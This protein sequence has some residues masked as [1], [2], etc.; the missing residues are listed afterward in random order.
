MCKKKSLCSA[1]IFQLEADFKERRRK[2]G[3]RILALSIDVQG[4]KAVNDNIERSAGSELLTEYGEA[5]E[6]AAEKAKRSFFE[7][8]EGDARHPQ[9]RRRSG[10]RRISFVRPDVLLVRRI[11]TL[12]NGSNSAPYRAG[13]YSSRGM[14][15]GKS[16]LRIQQPKVVEYEANAKVAALKYFVNF[17]VL[18]VVVGILIVTNGFV[19]DEAPFGAL[20]FTAPGS[21]EVDTQ[22]AYCATP[23][24]LVDMCTVLTPTEALLEGEWRHHTDQITNYF[25]Q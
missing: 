25:I 5:L 8:D 24:S 9:R 10:A 15:F 1:I 11:F 20:S 7:A 2:E 12:S 22:G 17:I 18:I 23:S 19:V 13:F 4:L 16:L 3:H 21:F 14:K 6:K